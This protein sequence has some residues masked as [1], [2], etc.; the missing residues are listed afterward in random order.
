[1]KKVLYICMIIT[2]SFFSVRQH[3]A[4][5]INRI[6]SQGFFEK[7]DKSFNLSNNVVHSIAQ[8]TTG[9]LWIGTSYGL[10]KYDGSKVTHY[11]F[12]PLNERSIGDNYIQKIFLDRDGKLWILV[13]KYLCLY[14]EYTDTFIRYPYANEKIN[15]HRANFGEIIDDGK[16]ML[17]IG[18]P[19]MGFFSF[20]KH[21]EKVVKF[22][23]EV[24]SIFSLVQDESEEALWICGVGEISKFSI[25][26]GTLVHYKLPLFDPVL[27]IDFKH[28][29]VI[30]TSRIYTI[31]SSEKGDV[32]ITPTVG[33]L[34]LENQNMSCFLKTDRAFWIGS[35]R[36]GIMIYDRETQIMVNHVYNRD[37]TRSISNNSV[38]SI[39]EDRQGDIWIGTSDGLNRYVT[40]GSLSAA[41]MKEDGMLSDNVLSV[42][43]DNSG[44][45]WVGGYDGVSCLK[46]GEHRFTSYTSVNCDGRQ[47]DIS[48]IRD[49]AQDSTGN[50]WLGKKECLFAFTPEGKF[51]T[52][53]LP[54]NNEGCLELLSLYVDNKSSLLVGT[55][56]NG[57]YK[58]DL[59][60][61]LLQ[62]HL[63]TGNSS[64]SSNYIKDIIRLADGRLCLATLRT[65]IDI[66][67]PVTAE[68]KNIRFSHLTRNYVSDFI[69]CV[70]QDSKGYLWVLS[71]FGAY[72]LDEELNLVRK[73]A[74]A[75][76]IAADEL[77][78]I[79]E[80]A[81]GD[82]WLGSNNGLSR[83]CRT[84]D[85]HV[86]NYSTSDG[87]VSNNISTGCIFVSGGKI[88]YV[89][90]VNGLSHFNMEDI[91]IR[92]KS[93]PPVITGLKIFNKEV[94]PEV[95]M[96]GQVVLS[97]QIHLM[98]KID[99]SHQ[100]KTLQIEFSVPGFSDRNMVYAYKLD[101]M[102]KDWIYVSG[103]MKNAAY[104][105]L[106]YRNYIFRVK[107]RNVDGIWSQEKTLIITVH[108]PFWQT[109]WAYIIYIVIFVV[110]M[111]VFWAFILSKERL[112]NDL[113]IRQITHQKENEISEMKFNFFT[114]VSHDLRTPLTLVITPLQHLLKHEQLSDSIRNQLTMVHNNASYL[115]SLINQLL[116]FRKMEVDRRQL[117]VSKLDIVNFLTEVNKAFD[118]YARQ[119]N[120]KL[121]IATELETAYLWFDQ[122]LMQKVMFNLIGNALKFTPDGGR[123]TVSVGELPD[124]VEIK[125]SD[126]GIGV[127]PS[128][129]EKIFEDFYQIHNSTESILNNHTSGSGI[130]LSIVKQYVEMHGS[131]IEVSSIIGQGST[132]SFRLKKGNSHFCDVQIENTSVELTEMDETMAYSVPMQPVISPQKSEVGIIEADTILVVD[133][134][135]EILTMLSAIL[136]GKFNLL[137]SSRA[138]EALEIAQRELPDVILSD[139]MMPV[140]D[141]FELAEAIKN[142]QL[143]AHIPI[144]FLTAKSSLADVIQGLGTGASDYITKP[145]SED[146]LIAKI[147]NL[148]T[149]RRRLI[150][151]AGAVESIVK[152]LTGTVIE[153]SS[154]T[155]NTI[156]CLEDPLV[157]RIVTF[158]EANMK[159]ID[160]NAEIIEKHLGLSK[161]Q[162]YRKLKAV[163]GLSVSDVIKSVRI[164]NACRL[165]A[166]SELNVSEIAYSLGFSDP[167][168][169]SKTFKK[170][171]GF[172]PLQFRRHQ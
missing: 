169:F 77:T 104:S 81:N 24:N 36:N 112:K 53:S 76:G 120:I 115:L 139:V 131:K 105:N 34:N 110:L 46:K 42:M 96:N 127:D 99:L 35:K 91:P 130:G 74:S 14:D 26:T 161:M 2:L 55:Y 87:L 22:N 63:D 129:Q 135:P 60:S 168:Y 149:D 59:S 28:G 65:G 86:C 150:K 67:N 159:D 80:D 100:Q 88:L 64:L 84:G 125:V 90:T 27:G 78:S 124:C 20:D 122:K 49:I 155:Y 54:F 51:K 171:T 170:E 39:F 108:P 15:T 107:A 29:N 154:P 133:D 109:W 145:F 156:Y 93:I 8:D 17:W 138:D 98:D 12:D 123:V 92:Y 118:M 158:I 85:E 148:M 140:M 68:T 9:F 56:G 103:N 41:Y 31:S 152:P 66:Y 166:N 126:T 143:T 52:M 33:S 89:G 44:R 11:F 62:E 18:T 137:I 48:N 69:N 151:R 3:S 40:K 21:N 117:R 71:W 83:I 50:I 7:L 162:L 132:F 5:P 95:E 4:H 25:A 72:V 144:L 141:G 13:P 97:Q 116:D 23:L 45:L 160:L 61:G 47:Y 153:T 73:F 119:K 37:D 121:E 111:L 43:K 146:I 106:Y 57:F 82:I 164:T 19:E 94:R 163:A 32:S 38:L 134:N 70:F 10:N 114:R 167:L 102:D 75:D 58:I 113:R 30:T 1:M 79:A 16:G 142:N 136:E 165:L 147:M 101:G 6:A 128:L 172:S 157:S